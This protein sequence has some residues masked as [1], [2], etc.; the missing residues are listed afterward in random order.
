MPATAYTNYFYRFAAVWLLAL[1]AGSVYSPP[2]F[3]SDPGLGFLDLINFSEGGR[4]QYHRMPSIENIYQCVE[5]RTTWWSPGQWFFVY[6][7]M[8]LRLP[9]GIAISLTVLVSAW[10]GVTGWLKLYRRFQ[11]NEK[12]VLYAGLLIIFS[13]YLFSAFQIYPGAN[14]LEFAAAPWLLL[15]WFK[16]EQKPVLIRALCLLP[17]LIGSYF[18]KSSMLIFWL[19]VIG[20]CVSVFQLKQLSIF[21][22]AVLAIVFFTGKYCCD[23]LFTGGGLTP[24]NSDS[25]WIELGANNMILLQ[26]FL[27]TLN[28]PLLA[29]IGLDDYVNYFLQKPGS[30]IFPDGHIAMLLIYVGVLFFFVLLIRYFLQ[31]RFK[32]NERY[33]DIVVAVAGVFIAFFLYTFVSGKN[34]NAYEESRHFRLAGLFLLP[35][36]VQYVEQRV[37]KFFIVIPVLMFVYAGLSSANKLNST[38]VL[39]PKYRVPLGEI[40]SQADLEIFH[41]A[42]KKSDFTYVIHSGLK[43]DLDHCKTIYNQ[44]DFISLEVI[45]A[46][47]KSV[48]NNKTIVFLLPERFAGNGKR[49]AILA[50]FTAG[51]KQQAPVAEI[52]KLNNWELITVKYF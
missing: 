14:I 35:L 51:N 23:L 47:P 16:L 17:M 24:F 49:D 43:Y 12:V 52:R 7:F 48:V 28:G 27:F 38:K 26:R 15:L 40:N 42:E 25:T 3:I 31:Q 11:F 2:S 22:L 50:N 32:L 9:L 19:G 33:R 30:V 41:A 46:R 37:K 1:F 21:R 13:R 4:F 6:L 36:V 5:E 8:L 10:I 39:S 29:S 18:I 44:D 34:I 45:R 20:S